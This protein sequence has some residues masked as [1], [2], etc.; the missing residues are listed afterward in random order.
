MFDEHAAMQMINFVLDAY[1]QQTISFKRKRHPVLV[2]RTDGNALGASD[3]FIN[4]WNV[5]EK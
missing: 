3:L 4:A 5:K 2:K 1:R